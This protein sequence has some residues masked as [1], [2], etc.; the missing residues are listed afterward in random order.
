MTRKQA[1]KVAAAHQGKRDSKLTARARSVAEAKLQ[2][3]MQSALMKMELAKAS[4]QSPRDQHPTY[5][6][7]DSFSH[8]NQP[9]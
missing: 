4:Y 3:E 9:L 5:Q 6:N 1:L 2:L 8:W 7:I